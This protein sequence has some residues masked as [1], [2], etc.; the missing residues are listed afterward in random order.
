ME[1]ISVAVFFLRFTTVEFML[2]PLDYSAKNIFVYFCVGDEGFEGF[3][4]KG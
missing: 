4:K 3:I 1:G 2:D